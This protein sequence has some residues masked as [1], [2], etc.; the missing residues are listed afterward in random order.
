VGSQLALTA[1]PVGQLKPSPSVMNDK[2]AIPGLTVMLNWSVVHWEN[3]KPFEKSMKFTNAERDEAQDASVLSA[4]IEITNSPSAPKA[5]RV[6]WNR[7]P[8]SVL[9]N[10]WWQSRA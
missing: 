7:F 9:M 2:T 3:W 6:Y 1:R 4:K 8:N 5:F 10:Y